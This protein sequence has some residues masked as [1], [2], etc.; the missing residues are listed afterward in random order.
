MLEKSQHFC[1]GILMELEVE[2]G[3]KAGGERI[4]V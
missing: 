1:A 4:A 3:K 2:E